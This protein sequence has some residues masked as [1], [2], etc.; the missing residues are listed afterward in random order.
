MNTNHNEVSQLIVESDKAEDYNAILEKH[1]QLEYQRENLNEAFD[2]E[3]C[4]DEHG[5]WTR[6]VVVR[7]TME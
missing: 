4:K 7:M 1:G 3:E 6:W 2:P 5:N